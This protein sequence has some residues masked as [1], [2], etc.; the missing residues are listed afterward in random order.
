MNKKK[1]HK[2]QISSISSFRTDEH[3]TWVNIFS[4]CLAT[5]ALL[6]IAMFNSGDFPNRMPGIIICSF[7]LAISTVYLRIQNRALVNMKGHEKALK[8]I[9]KKLNLEDSTQFI[10]IAKYMGARSVMRIFTIL[11]IVGWAIGIIL[12]I[13][14]K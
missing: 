4:A 7:G 1:W 13:I 10:K 11:Q 3:N 2:S 5:T 6:F 8:T 12:F 9:E 14:F